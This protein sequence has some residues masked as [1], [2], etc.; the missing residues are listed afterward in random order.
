V[1]LVR[2][3]VQEKRDEWEKVHGEEIE[4]ENILS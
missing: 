1:L 3:A 4:G 2:V